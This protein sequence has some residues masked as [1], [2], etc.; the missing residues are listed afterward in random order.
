[1][2]AMAEGIAFA[3]S[4]ISFI[5]FFFSGVRLLVR[6]ISCTHDVTK[7]RANIETL[8]GTIQSFKQEL[9]KQTSNEALP[10]EQKLMLH[11]IKDTLESCYHACNALKDKLDKLTRHS[12]NSHT[13]LWDRLKWQIH[14]KE[15]TA[16]QNNLE[17]YKSLTNI[18]LSFSNL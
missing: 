17:S 5:G 7:I 12:T 14:E 8:S 15:I 1:M 11:K 9:K 6:T 3:T 16:L 4:A 18:V 2:L 10:E 13:S